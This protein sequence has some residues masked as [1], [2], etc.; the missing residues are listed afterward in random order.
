MS[1]ESHGSSSEGD[2]RWVRR[3]GITGNGDLPLITISQASEGRGKN[4]SNKTSKY[5]RTVATNSPRKM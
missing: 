5:P 3:G 1:I 2:R 4:N